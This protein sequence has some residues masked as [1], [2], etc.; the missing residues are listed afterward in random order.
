MLTFFRKMD[1]YEETN[2]SFTILFVLG[3]WH[4]YIFIIF[5]NTTYKL[6]LFLNVDH[7][8]IDI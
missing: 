3:T 5:L 7:I 6:S 4:F 2:F 8:S 1:F